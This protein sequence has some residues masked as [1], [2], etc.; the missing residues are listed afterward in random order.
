LALQ[1]GFLKGA[2]MQLRRP[3]GFETAGEGFMK[4]FE[5]GV[6][7]IVLSQGAGVRWLR[8]ELDSLKVKIPLSE[9]C[10]EEL[11][12]QADK[13]AWRAISS[14]TPHKPYRNLLREQLVVQAAMVQRWTCSDEKIAQEDEIGQVFVRIAR[15]YALP[16]P[17]KLSEPVAVES[18]QLRPAAWRWTTAAMDA[19]SVQL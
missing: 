3:D 11:V 6:R 13:E 8:D 9:G 4:L 10:V 16:R 7:A 17:W 5:Y 18:R 12:R 1:A 15:K 14:A 2:G 19:R